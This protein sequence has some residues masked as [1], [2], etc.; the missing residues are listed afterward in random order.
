MEVRDLKRARRFKGML[1]PGPQTRSKKK[2]K[3]TRRTRCTY[4]PREGPWKDKFHNSK[5]PGSFDP[6]NLKKISLRK[7]GDFG[8]DKRTG[9]VVDFNSSLIGLIPLAFDG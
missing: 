5:S 2:S 4:S 9:G 3:K 1:K 7:A 6:Q 8:A